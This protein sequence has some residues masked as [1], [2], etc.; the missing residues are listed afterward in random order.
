MSA[1]RSPEIIS[2]PVVHDDL[3]AALRESHDRH[4]REMTPSIHCPP[5]PIVPL[6]ILGAAVDLI[7][8]WQAVGPRLAGH[9]HLHRAEVEA[10]FDLA[11]AK[12][13][14]RW[15]CWGSGERDVY[16]CDNPDGHLPP[17]FTA[18]WALPSDAMYS[19]GLTAPRWY[20]QHGAWSGTGGTYHDTIAEMIAHH[21]ARTEGSLD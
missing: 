14:L 16:V 13:G 17:L 21:H 9:G 5:G 4:A 19:E 15:K 11:F 8:Y 7:G 12:A 6:G 2:E 18:R 20:T 10:T 3:L 1:P